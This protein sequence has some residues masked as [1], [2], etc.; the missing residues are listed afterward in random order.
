M[1][2]NAAKAAIKP[3]KLFIDGKYEDAASG[4]TSP[5]MNPATGEQLT[6]VPDADAEDVD[7]AVRAARRTFE[8]RRVA[9]HERLQARADHLAH[10]RAD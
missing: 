8:S 3:G 4:K 9:Q 10:R 5:V 6:T 1:D 2:V 7:R